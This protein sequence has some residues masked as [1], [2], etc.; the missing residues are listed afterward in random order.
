MKNNLEEPHWIQKE[1]KGTL[2][3]LKIQPQASFTQITGVQGN[4]PRLKI[5]IA[6]PPVDGKANEAL[7]KFL[8]KLF[9]IPGSHI[10]I[11]RGETS[12]S[13]DILLSDISIQDTE[14]RISTA[15][16]HRSRKSET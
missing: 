13:K 3:R 6:A 10:H 5:R 1:P 15:L 11:L 7:V 12:H 4:P 2:L 8:K 16:N 9:N 14:S